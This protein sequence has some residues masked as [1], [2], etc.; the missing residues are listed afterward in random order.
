VKAIRVS[1]FVG[2]IGN[3]NISCAIVDIFNTIAKE[4]R[5]ERNPRDDTDELVAKEVR[6]PE[7]FLDLDM[8][9]VPELTNVWRSLWP[10]HESGDWKN[11]WHSFPLS[12]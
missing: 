8:R 6:E 10:E 3:I 2:N 1:E 11:E 7:R 4:W 5:V 12:I 9:L